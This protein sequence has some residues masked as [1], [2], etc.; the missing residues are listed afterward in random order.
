MRKATSGFTIVELLVVISIIGILSTISTTS[1]LSIKTSARDS[2]R[3]SK[4]DIV[5][6]ALEKY[7]DKNGEYPSCANMTKSANVV[8]TSL[9]N[10]NPEVLKSPSAATGTNSISSCINLAAGIDAIAYVGDGSTACLTGQS[11]PKWSLQYSEES[12]GSIITVNSRRRNIGIDWIAIGTQVWAKANL[13]AGTMI[14]GATE[15]TKNSILEKYCY[16]NLES[17]CTTYGGL[18]QW[19]EAMQYVT[20]QGAQG[21]CPAGSHIPSDNDWKILEVQLGMSQ[22]Q[23]DATGWRGTDQGTQLKSGGSSGLNMPLAGIRDSDGSFGVLS[24]YGILWSSSESSASAWERDSNSGY[25]TV[26]RYA[27][28]KSSGFSVRCLGN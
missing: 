24:S 7:Y 9:G 4:I 21:M 26:F 6:E 22:A 27:G 10:M 15:Q 12:T 13:N 16:N 8:S 20:T 18:Y 2:E 1:Y 17:N 25:A 3:S 5:A 19:D 11:C 14:A 23:A 28:F